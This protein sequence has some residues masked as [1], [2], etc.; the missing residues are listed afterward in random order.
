MQ[1]PIAPHSRGGWG[2]RFD[3]RAG[4]DYLNRMS[5]PLN[6]AAIA[7]ALAGLP[8]WSHEDDRLKKTY[9]FEDFSHA[10]AFIV[11]VGLEA[12]KMNHHPE[13]FNVYNRVEVALATHDADGKVTRKDVNLAK[14]IEALGTD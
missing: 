1:I 5:E 9:T 6:T 3:R 14:A 2:A 4:R 11:R 13:L 12:E 10:L 8:G 7:N